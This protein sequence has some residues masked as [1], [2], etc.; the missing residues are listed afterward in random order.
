MSGGSKGGG[1]LDGI[2]S[3]VRSTTDV[4]NVKKSYR[5]VVSSGDASS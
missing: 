5:F 1:Y 3:H 2:I 4:V